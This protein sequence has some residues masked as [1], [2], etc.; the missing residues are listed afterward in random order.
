MYKLI[1]SLL[2]TFFYISN[3]KGQPPQ[4]KLLWHDEFNYFGLPDSSKWNYEVGY[5]RN[6]E[7]QYYTKERKR[8]CR[9]KRGNLIIE[10]RKENYKDYKF[11]SACINNKNKCNFLYGKVEIRAKIPASRGTLAALWMLPNK[12]EY[13][14]WLKSGEID[15]VERVGHDPENLHFTIHTEAFNEFARTKQGKIIQI[16]EKQSRASFHI[17]SMEWYPDKLVFLLDEQKVFQFDK[18]ADDYR[19]WPFDKPF[20]LIMNL[21][22][23]GPW[24]G[25]QGIDEYALPQKLLID[26]VRIYELK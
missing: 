19:K 15:L 10:C 25:R 8:N 1:L 6:D 5:V 17:Y 20:Y 22:V 24:G 16:G 11:T 23:G 7:L 14:D 3:I 26:Y 21:A 12:M 9:V 2:L 4:W 18:Q 13:G